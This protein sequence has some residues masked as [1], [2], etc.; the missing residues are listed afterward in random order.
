MSR[1]SSR[2]RRHPR[3]ASILAVAAAAALLAGGCTSGQTSTSRQA[4]GV[5]GVV[6]SG[7]LI[8]S[9]QSDAPLAWNTGPDGKQE[10]P[11][12]GALLAGNSP[13]PSSSIASDD[14]ASSSDPEPATAIVD[15]T[16]KDLGR[17]PVPFYEGRDVSTSTTTATMDPAAANAWVEMD[18]LSTRT[19]EVTSY[20]QVDRGNVQV[21]PNFT[22]GSPLDLW[23][24]ATNGTDV[25]VK[26]RWCENPK[27]KIVD[28]TCPGSKLRAV[29]L[30][31][32]NSWLGAYVYLS[33]QTNNQER[34]LIRPTINVG[35]SYTYGP[36]SEQQP[37]EF[38]VTR[39]SDRNI[40]HKI[41]RYQ[42]Q[43]KDGSTS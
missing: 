18:N 6:G 17:A 38:V 4:E 14:A 36:F 22:P 28:D 13:S 34:E 43:I 33:F 16:K 3:T 2:V 10:N 11:A 35:Q 24:A 39:Q 15:A 7:P 31:I 30:D 41:L 9:G 12:S 1:T 19:V 40:T 5:A 26:V 27:E 42:F 21:L 29:A 8:G 32:N 23:G 20:D 25:W 37:I